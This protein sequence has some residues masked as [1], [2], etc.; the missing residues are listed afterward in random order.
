V[1]VAGTIYGKVDT[2]TDL[3]STTWNTYNGWY[4]DL[5]E[6]GERLLKNMEF[7]DN[8]NLLTV[9]TQA[10]AKG[11]NASATSVETCDAAS[12]DGERQYM[13]LINIMDGKRPSVQILDANSDNL[14]TAAGD[15]SVSRLQVSNGPHNIVKKDKFENVDID[16]KNKKIEMAAMPEQSLR[17]SWRQI[18]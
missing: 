13:T 8:S 14:Y 11:S 18:K 1:N 4:L 16:S 10:P 2:V 6:V 12:V 5:P 3:N 7:Y 15:L 9:Y 17:P